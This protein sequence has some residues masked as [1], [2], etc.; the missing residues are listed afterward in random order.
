MNV[1][2]DTIQITSIRNFDLYQYILIDLHQLC[3]LKQ[4]S[5]LY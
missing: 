1:A 2:R 4:L 5:I 3:H